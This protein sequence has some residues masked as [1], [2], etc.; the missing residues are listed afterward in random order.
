V[1]WGAAAFLGV[2]GH[3]SPPRS[4]QWFKDGLALAAGTNSL[5][6]ITNFQEVDAGNYLVVVANPFGAVTSQ[7]VTLT[8][9]LP[10]ITF[11][12]VNGQLRLQPAPVYPQR[13]LI[14]QTSTDLIHWSNLSTAR[15]PFTSIEIPDAILPT[16]RFY[17][18]RQIK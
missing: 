2:G 4:H 16:N 6:S 10:A 8:L 5:L 17:R 12:R 11:H 13:E 15:P 3:G 18:A 7:V 1:A 14:I 9:C